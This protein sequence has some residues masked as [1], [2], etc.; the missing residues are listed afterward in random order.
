[1]P[2]LAMSANLFA[3]RHLNKKLLEV[4]KATTFLNPCSYSSI[5]LQLAYLVIFFE[6]TLGIPK[7]C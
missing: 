1:M 2:N 6:A 5:E 3:S 7:L 4:A